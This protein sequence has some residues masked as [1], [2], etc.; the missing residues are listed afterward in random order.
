MTFGN[1]QLS[2]STAQWFVNTGTSAT[3]TKQTNPTIAGD[4]SVTIT[5]PANSVSMI[6]VQGTPGANGG[7]LAP[8]ASTTSSS[9]SSGDGGPS[10]YSSSAGTRLLDYSLFH[11]WIW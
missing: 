2:G 6:V 4:G 11:T 3:I 10:D 5:F 9:A 1:F 7:P 8:P